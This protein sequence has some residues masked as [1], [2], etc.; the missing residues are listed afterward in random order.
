MHFAVHKFYVEGVEF[1]EGVEVF[2]AGIKSNRQA[3]FA[4][5]N[6]IRKDTFWRNFAR[7]I[8]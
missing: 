8:Q 1:P 3:F 2:F 5:F 7:A 6:K 4:E